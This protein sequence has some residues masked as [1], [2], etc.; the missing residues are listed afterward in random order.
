MREETKSGLEI[1]LVDDHKIVREGLK[2][3]L[4]QEK[5]AK[6][7]V[8]ADN[9]L[10]FLQLLEYHK[11]DL[12]LMDISM[13]VMNG[14]DATKLAIEK[15]PDIKVLVLTMYD[16]QKYYSRLI[17]I[18][19]KGFILK[20]SGKRE[21]EHAIKTVLDNENYFSSKLLQNMILKSKQEKESLK[22]KHNIEF[23]E[24]EMEVLELLCS[25]FSTTEIAEKLYLSARTVETHRSNLLGKTNTKNTVNLVMFAI[26]NKIIN[27]RPE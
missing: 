14:M 5:I 21:L 25:G 9:G 7:I 27:L 1:C 26:K 13:P 12:V 17:E 24:R 11:F 10:E 19:A 2:S 8:E 23:T 18:G 3:L 20:T 16:D 6:S 15:Y 22:S 4:I